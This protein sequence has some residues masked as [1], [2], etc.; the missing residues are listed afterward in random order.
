MIVGRQKP[1]KEILRMLEPY[2]RVIV[3]GCGGCVT[4]CSAGGE[5]EAGIL[6]SMIKVNAAEAGRVVE[7]VEFTVKRQC[8][9]EFA[10]ELAAF[11][12]SRG[13]VAA[14][15]SIACGAGVQM[16]SERNEG[17]AVFPGLDTVFV[18]VADGPG[19]WSERCRAC[20]RCVLHLTAG[21][22]PVTKCSKSL[23]NGPCG[24]SSNG[25]C[26]VS[27]HIP[28]AWNQI[29]ERLKASGRLKLLETIQPP[30]DWSGGFPGG[31]R[32]IEREDL[33]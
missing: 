33:Q 5:K 6:G 12:K 9:P 31:P 26:E 22:C 2:Q 25:M 15:L 32:K 7:T 23:F 30:H 24:G 29:Y 17:T 27:E 28:C 20:G 3:A 8:E 14:V 19:K 16:T 10:D 1:F 13:D 11:I 4:V 18:G 21:I